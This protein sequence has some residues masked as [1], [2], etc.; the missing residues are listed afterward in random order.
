MVTRGWKYLSVLSVWFYTLLKI[1]KNYLV[2]VDVKVL[3]YFIKIR[4]SQKLQI[5]YQSASFEAGEWGTTENRNPAKCKSL[6]IP[7]SG[8]EIEVFLITPGWSLLTLYCAC[9]H[10]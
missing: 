9:R 1:Y 10:T 6:T 8:E 5:S 7:I 2:K 4:A 3:S